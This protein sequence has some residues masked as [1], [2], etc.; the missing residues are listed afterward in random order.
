MSNNIITEI[1]ELIQQIKKEY[2]ESI[3]YEFVI[4]KEGK[5]RGAN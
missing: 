5:N 4:E 1:Q 2:K 3:D